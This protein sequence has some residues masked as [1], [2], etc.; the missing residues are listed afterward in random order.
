VPSP[1]AIRQCIIA[2]LI[3]LM[4]PAWACA[5]GDDHTCTDA[6]HEL[7]LQA[8]LLKLKSAWRLPETAGPIACTV[9]IKQNWRG[10]VENVGIADCGDDP[11]VH[12]SVVDA[13]YDASPMPMPENKACFSN[14]VIVR[15]ESRSGT[16]RD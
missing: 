11:R 8:I 14:D 16:L 1:D 6:E 4:L 9:L 12:K 3:A 7:Y 15:L 13:G 5:T 10:E 2:S